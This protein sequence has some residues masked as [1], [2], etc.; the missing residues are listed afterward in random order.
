MDQEHINLFMES[1]PLYYSQASIKEKCLNLCHASI[2]FE[3]NDICITMLLVIWYELD[4]LI[5]WEDYCVACIQ[6]N[7]P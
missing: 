2:A 1:Y 5:A 7:W 6:I 3:I 4:N